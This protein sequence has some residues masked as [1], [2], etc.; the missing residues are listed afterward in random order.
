MMIRKIRKEVLKVF[1][2]NTHYFPSRQR[3]IGLELFFLLSN[4]GKERGRNKEEL[5]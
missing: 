2:F 5:N 3:Q 1:F 4:K